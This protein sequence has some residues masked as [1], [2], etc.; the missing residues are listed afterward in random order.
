ME[1]KKYKVKGKL[2]SIFGNY[3]ISDENDHIVYTA[4][5]NFF[6]TMVPLIDE[7]GHQVLMIRRKIFSL[8]YTYFIE[9]NGEPLYKVVKTLGLKPTVYIESLSRPDAFLIEGNIWGTEYAFYK[10]NE[11]FAYVSGKMFNLPGL[12]GV[13]I[14]EGE[15][16]HIVLALV[17]IIDLIKRDKRRKRS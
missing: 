15:D 13:A 3:E 1:F 9:I 16:T 8:R 11:E 12:Y 7:L 17:L 10:E 2:F 6:Q 5:S 4:K 14:K